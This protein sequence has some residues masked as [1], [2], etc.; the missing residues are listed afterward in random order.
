M[1]SREGSLSPR[2][3]LKHFNLRA[4]EAILQPSNSSKVALPF[5][6]SFALSFDV[7]LTVEF[8]LPFAALRYGLPF[9]VLAL[10]FL[11]QM[12]RVMVKVKFATSGRAHIERSSSHALATKHLWDVHSNFLKIVKA[13]KITVTLFQRQTILNKTRRLRR[14]VGS[15]MTVYCSGPICSMGKCE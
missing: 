15:A 11:P 1:F 3:L 8:A 10:F 2:I 12:K 4:F 7:H 14:L 13:Y 9:T 5:V 6:L